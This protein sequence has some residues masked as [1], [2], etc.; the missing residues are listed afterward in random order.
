MNVITLCGSTKFKQEYLNV[1]KWLTLQGNVVISVS[2]FGQSDNEPI[3]LSE[4]ILLDEIHK[5]KIDLANEIF[6]IDVNHYIGMST[7][8]EINYAYSNGKKVRF[9]TKEKD[10]YEMWLNEYNERKQSDWNI[11]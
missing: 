10:D 11:K 4:K 1:N 8:N 2:L 5:A 3:S 7:Q 6:V 9:F